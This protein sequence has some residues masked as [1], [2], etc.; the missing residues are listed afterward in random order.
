MT[1][2]TDFDR[3]YEQ[4]ESRSQAKYLK[5]A[6]SLTGLGTSKFEDTVEGLTK[7]FDL[8]SHSFEEN[9][10]NVW[11]TTEF[12]GHSAIDMATRYFT[13]IQDAP[14]KASVPFKN[15]V[16]PAGLLTRLMGNTFIH[17]SDNEV[18][19]FRKKETGDGKQMYV[20]HPTQHIYHSPKPS[21]TKI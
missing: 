19:F 9:Q 14:D 17:G 5:Q 18:L 4:F 6:I 3:R 15:N 11:T 16:D 2:K 7:I 13:P 1:H 8:Y 10:L 12:S 21:I 20:S